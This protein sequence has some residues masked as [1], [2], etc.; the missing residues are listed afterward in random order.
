MESGKDWFGRG[1]GRTIDLFN[2]IILFSSTT[3]MNRVLTV[4]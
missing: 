3:A 4:P 1:A 2:D